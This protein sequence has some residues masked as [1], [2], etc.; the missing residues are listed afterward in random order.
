MNLPKGMSTQAQTL[1]RAKPRHRVVSP[2]NHCQHD[3]ESYL[4]SSC[5]VV[6]ITVRRSA[7][8]PARTYTIPSITHPQP[9]PILSTRI[10]HVSA[11][12]LRRN[13]LFCDLDTE[14]AYIV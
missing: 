3:N 13:D 9:E 14:I 8:W 11:M 7:T 1:A 2:V 4:L 5:K 12:L 10:T 6:G